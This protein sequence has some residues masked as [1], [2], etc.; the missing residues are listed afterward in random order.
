MSGFGERAL[1]HVDL[2]TPLS[3]DDDKESS[4]SEATAPASAPPRVGFLGLGNV[5][6]RNVLALLHA[7]V[8]PVIFD[9]EREKVER[10]SRRGATPAASLA[11]LARACDVVFT[12]LPNT[13]PAIVRDVVLGADADGAAAANGDGDGDGLLACLR[14]GSLL[15]EMSTNAPDEMAAFAAACAARGVGFIDAPVNAASIGARCRSGT[16]LLALMVSGPAALVARALPLLRPLADEVIVC[17]ETVGQ[18]STCK[19]IH[20][21]VNAVACAAVGE[22]LPCGVK[23]GVDL[24]VLVRCLQTGGFGLNAGDVH[25]VQ[26]YWLSRRFEDETRLPGFRAELLQKDLRLAVAV[27]DDAGAPMPLVRAA[28]ANFDEAEARGWAGR[29]CTV[30]RALQEERAGSGPLTL[31]LGDG[32][33]ARMLRA[34]CQLDVLEYDDTALD[35]FAKMLDEARGPSKLSH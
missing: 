21:A 29:A 8:V 25:G 16:G 11:E 28:K 10:L 4:A 35:A 15:V 27:A 19:L 33:R 9:R 17:G 31:P 2:A 14:A 3:D 26:H 1:H 6:S 12:S 23:L 20:N 22:A 30:V 13:T 34:A 32:E 5:G 7:G 24:A 18:A